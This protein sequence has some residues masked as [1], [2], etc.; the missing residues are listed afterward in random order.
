MSFSLEDKISYA[1]KYPSEFHG[2][3][4][5]GVQRYQNY[6]KKQDKTKNYFAQMSKEAKRGDQWAKGVLAGARDAAKA[7]K[8]GKR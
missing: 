1:K 6:G 8:S 7:R 3:Y 5:V 4:Q 2:G